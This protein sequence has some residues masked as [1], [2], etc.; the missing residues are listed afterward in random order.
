MPSC[1]TRILLGALRSYLSPQVAHHQLQCFFAVDTRQKKSST[2][3]L[4]QCGQTYDKVTP[5]PAPTGAMIRLRKSVLFLKI[6]K[7]PAS[8]FYT[9]FSQASR[10]VPGAHSDDFLFSLHSSL[11]SSHLLSLIAK[12][13]FHMTPELHPKSSF[14][15]A[16]STISLKGDS[17]CH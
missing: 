3:K 12:K 11:Q 5:L 15:L 9:N 16:C 10:I 2:G 7:R 6:S 17:C 8:F 4:L 13:P 14:L 1:T